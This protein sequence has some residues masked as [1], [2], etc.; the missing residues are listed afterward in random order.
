MIRGMIEEMHFLGI[1]RPGE[2][3]LHAVTDDAEDQKELRGPA[4]GYSGRFRDDITGQVL[5]D[6]LVSSAQQKELDYFEEKK[7]WIL[8]PVGECREKTGKPPVTVRWVYIH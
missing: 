4:Q 8:R 2:V 7:V 6:E 3:G 1:A 5:I